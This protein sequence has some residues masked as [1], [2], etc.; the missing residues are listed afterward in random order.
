MLQQY[1]NPIQDKCTY[2]PYQIG[3]SIVSY[4]LHFPEICEGSIVL[5]GISDE[6]SAADTVRRHLYTLVSSVSLDT[7][8]IDL[9]NI[10][11]GATPAD[12]H[13]AIQSVTEIIV[14]KGG[15][16]LLLGT[17]IDQGESMYKALAPQ[18][19]QVELA[20]ISA[21]LPVL[22]Y[23][24][25]HRICTSEPNYLKNI[26]V[27]GF[28]AHYTP[29]RALEMLENL[30]FNHLRLGV[31]KTTIDEAEVLL[32]DAHLALFDLNAIKYSDA[33]GTC[34]VQANG[35]SG[36]EACQLARYAGVSDHLQ[37]FALLGYD[38]SSDVNE[39]TA[40]LCAQLIWYFAD[41]VIHRTTDYIDAHT[42]FVKYR[43]DFQK[44]GVPIHFLKSKRTARW[45]MCIA[46]PSHPENQIKALMVPCTYRDYLA[47]AN[48]ETPRRYLDNIKRLA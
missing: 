11:E 38:A 32:R 17:H 27:L 6:H 22:E 21:H 46:H 5:F 12:T 25:L 45:W 39:L 3:A 1:F 15:I 36:E 30:T 44:D 24:L 18:N 29:P 19:C 34:T 14:E 4:T 10:P 43:C 35:L 16:P 26:N 41:G 48:G 8:L 9:G 31:I 20:L 28:Q 47:A 7:I 13:A 42:D 33:P 40:A 37:C 2:K 23:Q